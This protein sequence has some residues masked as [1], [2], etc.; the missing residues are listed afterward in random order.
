MSASG[1]TVRGAVAFAANAPLE[2]VDLT[3]RAP[4]E[5]EVLVRMLAAGLCHSDLSMIEGK[6]ASYGFPIV[7]G[8]EGAGVVVTCG[9]GVTGLVPGDHVVPTPIPECR[10]CPACLSGRTN[11][12]HRMARRPESPLSFE[13]RPVEAFSSLATFAD[14][15]VIEEIRLAKISPAV[16]PE[17]AC[18]IGCGVITGVGSALT[19]ADLWPGCTVAVFGLGGVGLC[20]VQG[21]RM[22]G[23][24]RIIGIDLNPAR[25]AI[26][27]E[28]GATD[29][30]DP[31]AT[32]DAPAAIRALTA[33]GV[34]CAF[35]CVGAT[36]LM[37][38]ALHATNPAGGQVVSVGIPAS[39]SEL[40]FDPALF[41][42]G[43]SWK[44]ALLGGE[45]PRTVIPRLADWYASGFLRLDGLISH[46]LP[47]DEIN[48]GFAMMKSGEA[49][50]TVI[51]Y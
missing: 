10:Q 8:H 19:A 48:R 14:H 4:R 50:R 44:G 13:G 33:G 31:R 21:A 5:G 35:E 2:I 9:P 29:F 38:Q 20:V 51:L 24:A 39:G 16:P 27:R 6:I 45:K 11:L 43:R 1:M 42:T 37:Q 30:I 32:E 12:C 18:Y 23:A 49:V 25:E 34:D 22:A 47:L 40:R 7:P 15:A 46:R 36:A 26:A 17:I 41:M 28:Y 3:L